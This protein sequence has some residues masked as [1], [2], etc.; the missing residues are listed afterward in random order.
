MPIHPFLFPLK[1]Y[2]RIDVVTVGWTLLVGL[3]VLIGLAMMVR[4]LNMRSPR[5][6][7]NWMEWTFE[8]VTNMSRDTMESERAVQAILPLAFVMLVYLF[9]ANWLGLFATIEIEPSHSIP[10]LGITAHV[11]YSLLNSPTENMNMT[12]GLAVMVWLISHFKGLRHPVQYFKHYINPMAIIDEI[13]NPLTHGMRLFGN[14]LAGEVLIGA[15]LKMPMLFGWIPTGL[16]LLLI[17]LLYS[18]FVS[19]IQAYIFA[20]L[21]TL[22][23]GNKDHDPKPKT[24]HL[25]SHV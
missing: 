5:G 2:Y 21:L 14:I 19:T 20:L 13:T 7:Q 16:P 18:G 25:A 6:L 11:K 23:I 17:W 24:K 4:R 12:L 22:Y 8:F 1:W 15:I 9:V 3:F 10:W